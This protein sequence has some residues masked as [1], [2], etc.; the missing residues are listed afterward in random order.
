MIEE[1][2][3]GNGYQFEAQEVAD[4]LRTGRLESEIMPLD[5]SLQ[6]M[7]T[8]DTLRAQWNMRYPGE[9]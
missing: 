8:M 4:C 9:G 1:P 3:E 7:R 5:E 6:L 2:F